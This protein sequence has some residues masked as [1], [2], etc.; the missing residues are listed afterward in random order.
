M[1]FI[2][3][4][5]FKESCNFILD[6]NGFRVNKKTP[7]NQ[8]PVFF[9]KTDLLSLFFSKFKPNVKYK[10][11]THNSDI[12]L[13]EKILEFIDDTNLVSWFGQNTMIEHPKLKSIPIGVANNI[14]PHGDESKLQKVISENNEKNKLIYCSFDVS[15]N[16][17]ERTK[18][19]YFMKINNLDME[20]KLPFEDYLRNLSKSF[21]SLSPNGN[22]VDC[23]KLWE[24][25]YLKTI[26]IVT[27][28]VNIQF[29][30]NLPILVIP[31]WSEFDVSTLTIELYQNLIK[32]LNYKNL[33]LE[34][35]LNLIKLSK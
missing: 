19:L 17:S 21:F 10:L 13:S 25:L 31:S 27:S 8:I 18:C 3:G 15:T 24:S 6:E 20:T 4:N 30:K 28:S 12:H 26:P 34:Y 14:W 11:V 7:T 1:S 9:V 22:G 5:K 32:K 2:T 35:Y 29:Y 33:E 16:L 23:H